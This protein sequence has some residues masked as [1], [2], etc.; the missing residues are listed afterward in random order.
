[1]KSLS[2]AER[3]NAGVDSKGETLEERE[4]SKENEGEE[5]VQNEKA[6]KEEKEAEEEEVPRPARKSPRK[7]RAAPQAEAEPRKKLKREI[8]ASKK[9]VGAQAKQKGKAKVAARQP[10]FE[11]FI[12]AAASYRFEELKE[13]NLLCERGFPSDSLMPDFVTTTINKHEWQ[14]FCA[15]PKPAVIQIV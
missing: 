3:L 9:K 7:R 12:D 8:K 6:P 14:A 5:E 2:Q 1:M 11:R 10:E 13:H 15:Q 4:P